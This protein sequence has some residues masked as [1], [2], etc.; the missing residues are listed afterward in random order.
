MQWLIK[1]IDVKQPT[2]REQESQNEFFGCE[3][4]HNIQGW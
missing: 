3:V 1:F 4:L 2:D